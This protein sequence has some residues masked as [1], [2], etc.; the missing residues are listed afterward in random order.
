MADETFGPDSDPADYTV[1][2]VK[3]YADTV[4]DP[5]EVQRLLGAERAGADRVTLVSHLEGLL[6]PPSAS[7][8]HGEDPEK[9]GYD[10][11]DVTEA[12][13]N[14]PVVED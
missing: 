14:P 4:A 10:L 1:D 12:A 5:G 8:A 3:A 13:N 6:E 7:E 11:V 2:A 9:M